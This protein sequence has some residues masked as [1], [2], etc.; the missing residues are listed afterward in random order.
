MS[1]RRSR[2]NIAPE[3]YRDF[4]FQTWLDYDRDLWQSLL[5]EASDRQKTDIA[6]PIIDSDRDLNAI[7]QAFIN[8]ESSG[9]EDYVQFARQ[10][11]SSIEVPADRGVLICTPPYGVRLG[12]EAELGKLYKLR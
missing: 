10:E 7:R 11:V 8:A 1:I 4:G 9:L 12:N 3:L 5:K 6:L 2:L